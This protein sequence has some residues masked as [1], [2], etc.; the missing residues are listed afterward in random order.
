M[1]NSYFK[2]K[3]Y[4]L[5]WQTIVFFTKLYDSVKS[6]NEFFTI[7]FT[8]VISSTFSVTLAYWLTVLHVVSVSTL[9]AVTLKYNQVFITVIKAK[10]Y[11]TSGT[12]FTV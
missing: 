6:Q 11:K 1:N 12:A 3:T 5:L 10:S 8:L 9:N 4:N 2:T 7:T